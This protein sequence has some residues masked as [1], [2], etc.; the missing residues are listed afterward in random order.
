MGQQ[1][2]FLD[3]KFDEYFIKGLFFRK[4]KQYERAEAN[5][6]EA[7]KIRH[8]SL[9]AKN[10]LAISLQRQDKYNR[11]ALNLARFTY[12]QQ[13]TNPYFIV[14]YFKSLIRTNPDQTIILNQL[15]KDLR[16]SWDINKESFGD[17]LQAEYVFFIE[18]DFNRAISIYKD[19]LRKNP[20]YPVFISLHEICSIYQKRCGIGSGIASEIAKRYHFDVDNDDSF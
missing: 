20:L 9:T 15:I 5:Y 10:G 17:M 13:P 14:T 12:N 2:N 19:T 4:M 1:C 16:S 11:E 6:R 8:N 18:H 7:L 3:D